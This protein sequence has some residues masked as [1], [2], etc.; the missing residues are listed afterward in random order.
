MAIEKTRCKTHYKTIYKKMKIEKIHILFSGDGKTDKIVNVFNSESYC[1]R[2]RDYYAN[3]YPELTFTIRTYDVVDEKNVT[4]APWES[5][6]NK[7]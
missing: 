3:Q 5:G 7:K 6:T 4:R 2:F 1:E